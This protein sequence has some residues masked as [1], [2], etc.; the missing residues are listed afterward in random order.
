MSRLRDLI[1]KKFGSTAWLEVSHARIDAFAHATDDSQWIHVDP[2]RAAGGPYGT[3]IAHGDLTLALCSPLV[4]QARAGI[5]DSSV[6]EVP[7]GEQAV[8]V[9]TVEREGG[10]KP[11]GLAEIVVRRMR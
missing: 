10:E 4:S 11:V 7:G 8:L 1:G 9:T 2:V 3:T 5:T 6:D